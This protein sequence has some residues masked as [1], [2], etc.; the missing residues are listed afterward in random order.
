MY[1]PEHPKPQFMRDTWQNLNGTWQ[2]ERD[3]GSSGVARGLFAPDVAFSETIEVPFCPESRLSGIGHTDFMPSVWYKRTFDVTAAQLCGRILLHFGAVD[4]EATVYVNGAPCTAHRGGYSSFCIDITDNVHEGENIL[5]VHALDDTRSRLVPTGKQSIDYASA[6]CFYTRTTG[7]WQ[8]VWLEYVPTAYIRSVHYLT[9]AESGIVTIEADLQGAAVFGA[10]AFWDGKEVGEAS[11]CSNGGRAVLT[12][13]LS[14]THLWEVG[15]GGLYDLTLTYG[16]DTVHSYV[17]LRTLQLDG[18]RFLIN[19][20]PVFQRL[21]LD[22]GFYPDGIYTA[23]SD[24]DLLGDI[25]RSMRV[26]FN[27][28]RLHEKVFEERFLYHCDRLG[29]IVWGEFPSWGLNIS[30]ADSIYGFLPEWLEV[31]ER[32]RNHPSIVC[33]CPFNETWDIAGRKQF[34]GVL[35]LSYQTTKAVDP[36]RPFI[37][38]SGNFHVMTD[39]YDLHD[40]EQDPAVFASHYEELGKSNHLH[41]HHAFEDRQQ[42]DGKQPFFVSEYG[43]IQWSDDQ[44]G[45]GY[46]NAPKSREEFLARLKGL[47]DALL[48]H[49]H[50]MGFCYTQLTDVEQEQNGLYTYDRRPKFDPD[51]IREILSRRAAIEK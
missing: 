23:P 9:D 37:D 33:W 14:E 24:A 36:S 3:P 20:R 34:D 50:I 38:A 26:G 12:L 7:I 1:R 6:G 35:S 16:D 30:Y 19:G 25:E 21:V 40:Y 22:Q 47:T 32:D 51:V 45:W 44:N 2:F 28:A 39:V 46:G 27:G 8:T 4:Y 41:F 10:K 5:T 13:P 11:V 18:H 48:D 49:E 42:Y 43:G 29:Y 17:G 15:K 31:L